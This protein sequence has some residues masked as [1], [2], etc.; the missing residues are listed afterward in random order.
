MAEPVHMPRA[1][2][3]S[4][5][6]DTHVNA[7]IQRN[8]TKKLKNFSHKLLMATSHYLLTYSMENSPSWEANRFATS[9]E[10]PHIVWN[11]KVHHGSH[12]FPPRVLSWASSI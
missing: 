12:K 2:F 10:I 4:I 3:G 1:K 8:D 7:G 11:P 6:F 9:Q 5:S